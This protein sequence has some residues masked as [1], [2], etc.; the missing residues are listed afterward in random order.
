MRVGYAR[1][2]TDKQSLDLQKDAL[3]AAGCEQIYEDVISGGKDVRPGLTKCIEYLREGDTLVVYKLDRLGRS[4]RHL[5]VTIDELQQRGVG[6]ES[7]QE[8]IDDSPTGRL[9]LG[10]FSTIAEF[11]RNLIRERTMAG[12]AAARARGRKGGRRPSLTADKVAMLKTL[13]A[14]KSRS[15]DSICELMKI[16]RTTYYKYLKQ[17]EA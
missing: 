13:S 8:K 9:L 2:S 4:I 12:L 1:V 15:V 6:F 5:V 16:S 11:E 14:D 7:L 3:A 10:M 17:G